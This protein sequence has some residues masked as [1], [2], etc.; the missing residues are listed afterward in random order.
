MLSTMAC[1]NTIRKGFTDQIRY[2][3]DQGFRAIEDNGMMDR[4][5]EDQEKIETCSLN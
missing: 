5:P 3:Y 2:G 4:L 1:L